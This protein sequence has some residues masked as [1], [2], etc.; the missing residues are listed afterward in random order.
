MN[1]IDST[2]VIDTL[3]LFPHGGGG[4]YDGLLLGIGIVL[5]VATAIVVTGTAF[6][7]SWIVRG[8]P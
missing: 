1:Y 4:E 3:S 2:A 5:I 7:I 8:T 6:L